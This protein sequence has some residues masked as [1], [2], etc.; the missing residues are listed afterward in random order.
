R[1]ILDKLHMDSSTFRY[2]DVPRERRAIGYR[3]QPDGTY[4]EEPPLPQGAFGSAGALL[5]TANDLGKYVAFHLSAWP[6]RDDADNGPL[7]RSSL[8]EMSQLWTPSNLTVRRVGGGIE[9]V[10]SGY[11][12]GLRIR[13]DCR[14]ERIVAH[15]GG[16]PGFG[17]YMEWLPD[18]GVGLFAMA[19]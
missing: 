13:T 2:S 8:R 6:P 12:F 17:S 9:A 3:L 1:R 19:T 4:L 5:T 7:R 10:E 11:G 14:F 15:G 18:Y 16:L